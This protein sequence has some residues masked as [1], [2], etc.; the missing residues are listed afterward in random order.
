[1]AIGM[2]LAA[3]IDHLPM[4]SDIPPDR[5]KLLRFVIYD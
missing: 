2:A 5:Y 4:T 1:M 3:R